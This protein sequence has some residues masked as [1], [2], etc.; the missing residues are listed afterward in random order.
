MEQENQTKTVA[1]RIQ[2]VANI[3]VVA[4][5]FL[6]ILSIGW[7]FL[8]HSSVSR[9]PHSSIHEGTRLTLS[10]WN[11]SVSRRTL[12]L[13]LST[14]CKY[15]T[16]NA[17]FYRRL[18]N[19]T[20]LTKNTNLIAVLPQTIKESEEYFARLDIKI[21]IVRQAVPASLGAKGTPTLILVDSNGTVIDSWEEWCHRKRRMKYLLP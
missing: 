8:R 1:A 18:V 2:V 3:C 13:V 9:L 10:D 12:L 7:T 21:D 5:A 15:C 16:A 20:L 11:W 14:R 17:L 4:A 19:Q 6:F